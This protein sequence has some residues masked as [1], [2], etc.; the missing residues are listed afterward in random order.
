MVL[1]FLTVLVFVCVCDPF[2]CIVGSWL[3]RGNDNVF[4][5]LVIPETRLQLASARALDD[6]CRGNWIDL[7]DDCEGSNQRNVRVTMGFRKILV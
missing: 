6:C 7:C 5:L 3:I 4:V 2:V 1:N